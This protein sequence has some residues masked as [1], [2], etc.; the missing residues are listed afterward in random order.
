VS[1]TVAAAD[2]ADRSTAKTKSPRRT[3]APLVS[4]LSAS[5]F[6]AVIVQA[7]AGIQL[8]GLYAD[9]A[10]FAVRIA[11]GASSIGNPA[12]WTSEALYEAPVLLLRSLGMDAPHDVA[13]AFSVSTNVLPGLLTLL[14]L[15]ALPRGER[16]FFVFPAFVYLAGVLSA[17]FA[18][19]TEG[20]VATMYAWLL[21]CLV[22]FGRLTALRLALISLLAAGSIW[23]HE[24]MAFLGPVLAV[25][26]LIRAASETRALSRIVLVAGAG[27]AIAGTIHGI[28]AILNPMD[29]AEKNA[30]ARDFLGLRWLHT[31]GD[32]WNIPCVLGFVAALAIAA[33]MLL[34]KSGTLVL[35][36]FAVVAAALTLTAF[37]PGTVIDPYAQWTA[38][39]NAGLLSL[40]LAMLFLAARVRPTI[41]VSV[42]R[43]AVGLIVAVL[44][45]AVS[46]W[47]VEATDQ[48][49]SFRKH[50]S[51]ILRWGDGILPNH[52][53]A[54]PPGSRQAEID[55][56]M[57]WAWTNPDFSL[58]V[59]P[60]RC[61][62]SVV[63]NDPSTV[64][65][66]HD[67]SN[68]A[69]MPKLPGVTYAYSLPRDARQTICEAATT[70]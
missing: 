64:W 8:R 48:W 35:W 30:F 53:L 57:Q 66:P 3:A 27:L 25:A 50:F 23:S 37:W 67:P 26:C 19:V 10:Y 38:R 65:Q 29:V 55:A 28:S 11:S 14:C 49:T 33:A 39:N 45:V 70:R 59:L 18:S 69:T 31:P 7:Y 34:P 12:R 62:T 63:A 1:N 24:Q 6:I 44:G 61:I 58:A 22:G 32:A 51:D 36:V 41:A 13:L 5:V 17:Q 56:K 42:T 60:R 47:H 68:P 40:P 52:I 21:L 46:L 4:P 15:V 43:P 54:S 2:A 9:G 16:A 20:L